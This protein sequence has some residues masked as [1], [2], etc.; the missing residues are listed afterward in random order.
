MRFLCLVYQEEA[1][2]AALSQC[3]LDSVVGACSAWAEELEN[4]GHHIMSAGLQSVRSAAT[5]RVRD[6]KLST[7]DGPFAETKEYLG[8]FT[9]INAKD[10][11]EA[12]QI[13]AKFPAAHIGS[14]EVRPVLEPGE[15]V[16][17]PLDQRI[18][19]GMLES[20][21]GFNPFTP[22]KPGSIP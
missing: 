18:Q 11:D 17:D 13:A 15:A 20:A 10:L 4:T 14:M 16:A 1:K 2:L 21:S 9:L 22:S 8:G 3:E 12:L 5:V 6:G 19:A 7:T